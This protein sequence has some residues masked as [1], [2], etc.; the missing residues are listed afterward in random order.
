MSSES[1]STPISLYL[2]YYPINSKKNEQNEQKNEDIKVSLATF[3]TIC[4]IKVAKVIPTSDTTRSFII[5]HCF[6]F[7]TFGAQSFT[8]LKV[9]LCQDKNEGF[10]FSRC[11]NGRFPW[12]NFSFKALVSEL[13]REDLYLL[14]FS[15]G[16]MYQFLNSNSFNEM[17]H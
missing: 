16:L 6:F 2:E 15:F 9:D 4:A 3:V 12:R 17:F 11:L 10:A 14:L 13:R 5:F 1:G 8:S 7:S